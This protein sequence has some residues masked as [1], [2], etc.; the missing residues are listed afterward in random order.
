MSPTTRAGFAIAKQGD[1]HKRDDKAD[2]DL[3]GLV[4]SGRVN[5]LN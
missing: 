2:E 5:K 4:I 1:E 3:Y